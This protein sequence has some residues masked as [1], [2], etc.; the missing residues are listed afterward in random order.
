[1]IFDFDRPCA[2]GRLA[3][4]LQ[5]PKGCAASEADTR[6]E[7][8]RAS[9]DSL[10]DWYWQLKREGKLRTVDPAVQVALQARVPVRSVKEY[11]GASCQL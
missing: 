10:R 2:G 1:M 9:W 5:Q 11:F 8:F 4:E 3:E 7:R 6:A